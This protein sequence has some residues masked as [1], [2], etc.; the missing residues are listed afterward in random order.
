MCIYAGACMQMD[1]PIR[2][3]WCVHMQHRPWVASALR[4]RKRVLYACLSIHSSN[5]RNRLLT[6]I[7]VAGTAVSVSIM[8]RHVTHTHTHIYRLSTH[9]CAR[10][11]RQRA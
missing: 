10:A 9:T 7:I 2:W 1:D 11:H 4:F 6:V 3:E 5:G 8:V